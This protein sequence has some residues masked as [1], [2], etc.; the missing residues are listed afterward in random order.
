[1]KKIRLVLDHL[2]VET[3]ATDERGGVG[4][5]SDSGIGCTH[6][7]GGCGTHSLNHATGECGCSGGA[8]CTV[9]CVEYSNA[10]DYQICCG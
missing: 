2:R 4:A 3:F 6:Y 10:T 9:A 8:Q 7:E 5:L 1:M